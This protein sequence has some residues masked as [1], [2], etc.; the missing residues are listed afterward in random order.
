MIIQTKIPHCR[1]L[2]LDCNIGDSPSSEEGDGVACLSAVSQH[3]ALIFCQYKSMLD[4]IEQDLLK[5]V[6]KKNQ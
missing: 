2:L 4:I 1:Q 5:Y 3:R 6:T